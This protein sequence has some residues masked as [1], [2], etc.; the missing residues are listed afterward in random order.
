MRPG[1]PRPQLPE[2]FNKQALDGDLDAELAEIREHLRE[3]RVSPDW[4]GRLLEE[5]EE[6]IALVVLVWLLSVKAHLTRIAWQRWGEEALWA[7]LERFLAER[8]SVRIRLAA[9]AAARRLALELFQPIPLST[10]RQILLEQA[11]AEA[12]TLSRQIVTETRRAIEESLSELVRRGLNTRQI[13]ALILDTGI[14]TLNSRFA[15]SVLRRAFQRH[16]AFPDVLSEAES[17]AESLVSVRQALIDRSAAVDSVHLG[18]ALTATL[19]S[20]QGLV[21]TKTWITIPDE[22]RC[23]ICASLH[24]QTVPHYASFVASG[25]FGVRFFPRP[26][27]HPL[28]RCFLEYSIHGEG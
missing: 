7:D 20:R 18:M 25:S 11:R 17:L 26:K 27:A 23:P 15:R 12:Q 19:W 14:F 8:L 2:E 6:E 3:L 1:H 13:R 28:C 4:Y 24:G 9:L 21:V 22:R 5:H 10:L 16:E